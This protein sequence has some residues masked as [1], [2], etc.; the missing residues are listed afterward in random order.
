MSY[1]RSILGLLA[2]FG[3]AFVVLISIA[4]AAS[5]QEAT[6]TTS[7]DEVSIGEPLFVERPAPRP[8]AANELRAGPAPVDSAPVP[9]SDVPDPTPAPAPA[10][11]P[12]AAA[13]RSTASAGTPALSAGR[14]A[15]ATASRPAFRATEVQGV[16][17]ERSASPAEGLDPTTLAL[18]GT[19]REAGLTALAT[20]L[21]AFGAVL[22]RLGRSP[23]PGVAIP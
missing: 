12:A 1:Q 7:S 18:T 19:D 22:V 6:P 8:D 23:R 3:V 13:P 16:Q 17:I 11:T 2:S 10:P 5:A 20:V 14:T 4:G 21:L 9:A 15:P